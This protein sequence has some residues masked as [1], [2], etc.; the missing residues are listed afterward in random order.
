MIRQRPNLFI[1]V[2]VILVNLTTV[3]SDIRAKTFIEVA[4][5]GGETEP[6]YLGAQLG[7][8]EAN[9]QGQFLG[10]GFKLG[11][12]SEWRDNLLSKTIAILVAEKNTDTLVKIAN[13]YPEIPVLNLT[14][15][16]DNL[17]TDC[18]A[19]ILHIAPSKKMLADA[20]AQWQRKKPDT[21]ATPLAWH[22]T[23]K[24][25][26]ARDLNKRFR[27]KYNQAM[28]SHAWAGWAGIK[29]ISDTVARAPSTQQPKKLLQYLKHNLSFDGQKGNKLNFR[30]TGQLR[31]LILLVEKDEIVAEAPIRGV[32]QPP[33]LDSLGQLNCK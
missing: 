18:L 19:N 27:K 32:A 24:K 30:K 20:L 9:L 2:I 1:W 8:K 10:L 22:G 13:L 28:D 29:M 12:Y 6:S 4:Y 21:T 31:Q 5:I 7:L 16:D 23:F 15:V 33:T 11:H 17:R 14:M 26:A 3:P 25:F